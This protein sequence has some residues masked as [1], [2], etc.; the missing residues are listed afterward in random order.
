MEKRKQNEVSKAIH[1][2]ILAA[3]ALHNVDL[4]G[5]AGAVRKIADD[6]DLRYFDTPLRKEAR[7][8]SKKWAESKPAW[9]PDA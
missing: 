6:L 7:K 9:G 8:A 2:L 5:D 3:A 4:R 1:H